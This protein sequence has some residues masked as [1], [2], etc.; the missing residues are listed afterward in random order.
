MSIH[1]KI[2]I[3]ITIQRL[4]VV[5]PINLKVLTLNAP[6][7]QMI[8]FTSA[9]FQKNVLSK[10]IY[11]ENSKL[12]ANRVDSDEVAHDEPP[13]LD[14]GYLHIQQFSFLALEVLMFYTVLS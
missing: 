11:I 5:I 2:F 12:W 7:N 14:I 13:H 1:L 10:L 9:K 8:K 6:I 3:S 4:Y